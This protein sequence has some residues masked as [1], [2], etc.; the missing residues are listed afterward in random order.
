ME[1]FPANSFGLAASVSFSAFSLVSLVGGASPGKEPRK[2]IA[3]SSARIRQSLA[4]LVPRVVRTYH[5]FIFTVS[6]RILSKLLSKRAFF[7]PTL[8]F[9]LFWRKWL[10]G[11]PPLLAT[12]PIRR[13]CIPEGWFWHTFKVVLVNFDTCYVTANRKVSIFE[14]LVIWM[15]WIYWFSELKS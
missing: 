7:R 8:V 10:V 3:L 13:F 4:N 9:T 12:V 1:A 6:T 2:T 11:I 14:F 5:P 15:I